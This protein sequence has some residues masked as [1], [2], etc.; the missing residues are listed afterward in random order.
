ME[1]AIPKEELIMKNKLFIIFAIHILQG[2]EEKKLPPLGLYQSLKETSHKNII[3]SGLASFSLGLLTHKFFPKNKLWLK[4]TL[5]G[6]AIFTPMA[7]SAARS[8]YFGKTKNESI[9]NKYN[10]SHKTKNNIFLE[11]LY[12]LAENQPHAAYKIFKDKGGTVLR[13]RFRKRKQDHLYRIFNDI[14]QDESTEKRKKVVEEKIKTF[15]TEVSELTTDNAA[16]KLPALFDQFT[17]NN[18]N[19]AFGQILVEKIREIDFFPRDVINDYQEKDKNIYFICFFTFVLFEYTSV[20]SEYK[21]ENAIKEIKKIINNTNW[22]DNIDEELGRG[23]KSFMEK[24]NITDEKV[25]EL[26]NDNKILTTQRKKFVLEIFSEKVFS[27]VKEELPK[28]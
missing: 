27:Q 25:K 18:P 4:K 22:T 9:F 6:A 28:Q 26:I 5:T 1:L 23:I 20:L 17:T 19:E 11:R 7:I 13:D 2:S 21:K 14:Q 24:N 12:L 3:L 8:I 10:F 16:G 15:Q